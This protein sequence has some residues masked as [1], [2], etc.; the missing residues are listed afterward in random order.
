MVKLNVELHAPAIVDQEG[1]T[2]WQ[3]GEVWAFAYGVRIFGQRIY[4]DVAFVV[5][6]F[7]G[8]TDIL[9]YCPIGFPMLNFG[10][11]W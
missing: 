2:L 9:Q 10:V 1:D 5:P 8:V 4:G 11:Q 7:P 3:Y 6:I